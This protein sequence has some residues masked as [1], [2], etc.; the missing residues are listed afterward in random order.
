[1]KT[2]LE[3]DSIGAMNV[4]KNAYFGVHTVRAVENFP[5]TGVKLNHLPDFIRALAM[6]KRAA[7]K[8]NAELGSIDQERAD[9]IAAACQD[10]I[11]GQYHD[12]FVVDMGGELTVHCAAKELLLCRVYAN[13]LWRMQ[14]TPCKAIDSSGWFYLWHVMLRHIRHSNG[15]V[16]EKNV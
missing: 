5:I 7:A 8:A 3:F 13:Q 4:P 14:L 15:S 12:T 6:V 16:I 2:R 1:M 10:L 11:D 9:W